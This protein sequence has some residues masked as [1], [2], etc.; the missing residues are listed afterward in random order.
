MPKKKTS[1]RKASPRPTGR[2]TKYKPEY[3]KMLVTH[4][5]KGLS[6]EAFAGVVEVNPDTLYHWANTKPAF[7]E[8]KIIAF[9][10]NRLFWETKAVEHL[11]NEK[12]VSFNATSWIFNMK[13]RFGWRDKQPDEV[14]QENIQTV[15]IELPGRNEEQIISLGTAELPAAKEEKK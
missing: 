8:A 1:S 12:G 9:G 13:N 11:T 15:R 3:C 2:P 14:S 4:M 5:A 10:K 7:S 6:F